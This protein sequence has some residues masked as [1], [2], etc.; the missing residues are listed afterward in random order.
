MAAPK[1]KLNELSSKEG[2]D[3]WKFQLYAE[4]RRHN[5]EN[6][7]DVALAAGGIPIQLPNA[8]AVR[9]YVVLNSA[10]IQCL[11]GEALNLVRSRNATTA[12]QALQILNDA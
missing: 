2:F 1:I 6:A 3:N 4:M 9:A 12:V 10:I 8:N 11:S 5:I 7:V